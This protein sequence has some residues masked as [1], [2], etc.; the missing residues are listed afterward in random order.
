MKNLIRT[1]SCTALVLTLSAVRADEARDMAKNVQAGMTDFCKSVIRKDFTHAEQILKAH[2]SPKFVYTRT[3]GQTM[4][5][6]DWIAQMKV[7][8]SMMKSDRKSVV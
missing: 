8:F 3:N 4:K 1:M 7:Q 6:G 5:L 2:F